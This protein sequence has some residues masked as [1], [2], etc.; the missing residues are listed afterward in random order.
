MADSP[1]ILFL[2]TDDQRYDA[3]G[4]LYDTGIRTPNMDQLVRDGVAFTNAHIPGGTVDAICMP[5]RAMIHSGRSLFRLEQSGETIPD[6]HSLLGEL[7]GDAGYETFGTGKWHNGRT[8]YARSFSSGDE[9]FFGG[10]D[11][12]W[13]VPAYRFDPE[14]LYETRLPRI[15]APRENNHVVWRECDHIASGTHSSELF[16]DATIA[17]LRNRD[18]SR[19]FFAYTSFMAPHDPRSMPERFLSMYTPESVPFPSNFLGGHPF[20]NGALKV[21]DELL[22]EFPRD[23]AEVRQQIAE[24]YAMVSHLDFEIGRILDVLDE[25]GLTQ[26]TLIL[27]ASDHGL[28]MGSH[29]L[30]G[31]QNPYE[32]SIRVPLV[33]SGPGVPAEE[34]RSQLVYLFDLFPTILEAAGVPVPEAT[35]GIS[36]WDA[37]KRS[38][39]PL[40]EQL[41]FA[42]CDALR[43]VKDRRY[44]LIEYALPETR[45]TQ[46]FDLLEDPGEMR[47]LTGSPESRE[48]LQSLRGRLHDARV[49][50]DD[51]NH[52]QG[53]SF[54]ERYDEA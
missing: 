46:L 45:V 13:N 33:V 42:Y 54:W 25:E 43:G 22:A 21:R 26:N 28:A 8:A 12:H 17:F 11:D 47:N 31:K 7:L 29:G 32:H 51:L 18:R 49:E 53:R 38:D 2:L 10:M 1:N 24:Y 27:L 16:A 37:V 35:D 36:L 41:Y 34:K 50:W 23:P 30:M 14:G 39:S 5:S 44:K 19:P 52:P 48:L 9:I 40:R 4:A 3:I 20:D 6:S 15:P